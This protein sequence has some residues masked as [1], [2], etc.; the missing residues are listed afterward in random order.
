MA[1]PFVACLIL[2][3]IHAYLGLHVV[4]RG[5]IFVDLALAQVA[6]FG[7]TLGFLWGFGLHSADSY[8]IALGFTFVGAAIFAATRLRK[9]IVP[10]EALIGIV[11]AVS[12]AA[13]ILVLSRAPEGGEELKSL[14][15]GHLLFVEWAEIAKVG[16]LYGM[17]GVV[18]WIIRR[19]LLAISR[20]PEQA[21]AQGLRV[22]WWDFLFYATFGF[23]VTSSVEMAGVLLVFSFLIVPA[24]CGV[25]LAESVGRRLLVGW[26]TGTLTSV[27][28]VAA[29]YWWDLPTGATVVC[30]F[31]V[32]LVVCALMRMA[33]FGY[34]PG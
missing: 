5:V 25:L 33:R 12:A 23:V 13:S 1:R 18:H 10:Q 29:S 27:G 9:P 15:V 30:A 3:G 6:A 4:E 2:T 7:A 19:P 34:S 28:G 26:M 24:V 8:L 31:G 22:R 17:I 32:C 20:N 14:L 16:V 21:F 11:Y